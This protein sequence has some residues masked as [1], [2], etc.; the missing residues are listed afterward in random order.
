MSQPKSNEKLIRS[1]TWYTHPDYP[2]EV[3]I[4][5]KA[6]EEALAQKDAEVAEAV[7]AE[8][9]RIVDAYSQLEGTFSLD[10]LDAIVADK[11]LMKEAVIEPPQKN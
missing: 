2:L 6:F 9:K 10:V 7:L 3:F 8:R 11:K 5:K 4:P 1:Q